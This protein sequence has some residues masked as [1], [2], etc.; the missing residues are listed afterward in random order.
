MGAIVALALM[1]LTWLLTNAVKSPQDALASAAPPPPSR[2]TVPVEDRALDLRVVSTGRLV[3]P[4]TVRG[5]LSVDERQRITKVTRIVVT[6]AGREVEGRLQ[7]LAPDG[8]YLVVLDS[9]LRAGVDA[10]VEVRFEPRTSG[11]AGLVVPISALFTSSG[12]AV[13]VVVLEHGVE[14]EV[15]VRMGDSTAGFVSVAP[16]RAGALSAGDQVLV[17]EPAR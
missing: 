15:A 17:S 7:K 8:E 16:V 12:G 6:G 2:I 11:V 1:A 5:N 9:P 3:S 14:H 10:R 4:V 13:S